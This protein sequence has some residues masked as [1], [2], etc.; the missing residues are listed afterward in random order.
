G[1]DIGEDVVNLFHNLLRPV[2]RCTRREV[3]RVDDEALVFSRDKAC[4]GVACPYKYGY[5]DN[6]KTGSGN[7]FPADQEFDSVEVAIGC[8]GKARIEGPE[9]PLSE[10]QSCGAFLVLFSMLVFQQ[11]RAKCRTQCQ[12]VNGGDDNGDS[13]GEG[14]LP[15]EYTGRPFHKANRY[16]YGG[17]D[18]GN[19]D[20]RTGNFF[21]RLHSRR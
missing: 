9:E 11:Q 1:F 19:R 16:E 14:E 8:G 21:R 4:R 10:A 2:E 5:K 13:K 15:V 3:Y 7:P 12:R 6:G 18:H 17:H 20:D